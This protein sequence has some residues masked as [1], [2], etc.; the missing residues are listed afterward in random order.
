VL[1]QVLRGY[2]GSTAAMTVMVTDGL[3]NP[4]RMDRPLHKYALLS[5]YMI[6]PIG[7]RR[8]S[9]FY[10]ERDRVGRAN[11]TL[12]ELV[13]QGDLA[14]A[15]AYMQ[16]HEQELMLNTNINA[17]LE[18]LE[19]TRAYRKYLSSPEGAADMSMKER[20]EQRA[21]VEQMEVELVRWLR[22]AKTL[23]RKTD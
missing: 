5:N 6:D 12:N 13:K 10:E 20:E 11:S 22:E 15:E 19:Q 17:T 16:K 23:I 3:L 9:E 2:F 7:K 14:G 1:D 18:Q 4:T 8:I 21:E